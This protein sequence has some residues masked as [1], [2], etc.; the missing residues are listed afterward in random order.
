MKVTTTP[1]ILQI[2]NPFDIL[3][4]AQLNL[5]SQPG[6]DIES[7]LHHVRFSINYLGVFI[8]DVMKGGEGV[9]FYDAKVKMG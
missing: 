7:L 2:R 9:T 3:V 4:S 6:S 8:N 1:I 5:D